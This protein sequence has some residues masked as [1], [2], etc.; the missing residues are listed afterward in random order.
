MSLPAVYNTYLEGEPP[1]ASPEIADLVSLKGDETP[2]IPDAEKIKIIEDD[3]GVL[4]EDGE[5]E[6]IIWE[7]DGALRRGVAILVSS[8]RQKDSINSSHLPHRVLFT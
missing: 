8:L 6:Q 1:A 3:F 4:A 7:S 2:E 5:E